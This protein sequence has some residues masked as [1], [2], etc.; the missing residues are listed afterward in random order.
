[1]EIRL[2]S[3]EE[4]QRLAKQVAKK[5]NVN[6]VIALYG[7]LGSGK[8]TFTQYLVKALNFQ[9]KVQSPTFVLAR[10][11]TNG[12]GI[13]KT[14]NHLDL[15]R[16]IDTNEAIEIDPED[17]F[18]EKDAITIIEWPDI[19]ENILPDKTIKIYFS[20]GSNEN[21]RIAKIQNL[22]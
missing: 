3:T 13:I 6:D 15:Y 14:V 9:A 21:E 5:L 20:Y 7:E 18:Y 16:L 17:Y 2:S 22:H 12:R 8:T 11:Y 1:M 19:I 4:T 10:K